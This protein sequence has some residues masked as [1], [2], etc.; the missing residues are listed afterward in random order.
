LTLR[1]PPAKICNVR[2]TSAVPKRTVPRHLVALA[3]SQRAGIP[4]HRTSSVG[5][6]KR[7]VQVLLRR[8]QRVS[9]QQSRRHCAELATCK[10]STLLSAELVSVAVRTCSVALIPNRFAGYSDRCY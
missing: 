9:F 5:K 4:A 10:G 7:T 2:P 3:T 1:G 6:L 8:P